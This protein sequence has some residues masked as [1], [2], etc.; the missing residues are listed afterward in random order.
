MHVL[1]QFKDCL[2]LVYEASIP[3]PKDQLTYENIS[4]KGCLVNVVAIKLQIG[5][6]KGLHA[7]IEKYRKLLSPENI[8]DLSIFA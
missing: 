4:K 1:N 2:H 5:I 3:F 8:T 6:W 7:L